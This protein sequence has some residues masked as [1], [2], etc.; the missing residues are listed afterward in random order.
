MACLQMKKRAPGIAIGA[1]YF[2]AGRG[3]IWLQNVS[4]YLL[5][6]VLQVAYAEVPPVAYLHLL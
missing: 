5:V 1:A 4:V 6:C 3:K 2:G